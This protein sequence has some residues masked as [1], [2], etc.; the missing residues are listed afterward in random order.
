[1]RIVRLDLRR[2]DP[3]T[4]AQAVAV[5][6]R[7]GLVV[8]PTETAYGLACDPSSAKAVKRVF[9]VKGRD[10]SKPLPLVAAS[11]AQ[12]RR[13]AA[14]GGLAAP[15]AA[16][17]WPGPLS[18]VLPVRTRLA[19]GVASKAGEYALRV[20]PHPVAS[21][22]ARGLGRPIVATSAN[23]SGRPT[24]YAAME[25]LGD[26]GALPDLVLDAGRLK[27]TP[28]STLVRCSGEACEILRAG[29]VGGRAIL[30]TLRACV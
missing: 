5:L 10:P 22:L 9:A 6:R 2:P 15:L 16:A 30:K 13:F 27:K 21:A 4:L 24:P 12:A 14:L 19:P 8:F 3:K 29:P 26:L 20:S 7:G 17:Y 25:V 11:A 18:L 1:M 23:R 28:P